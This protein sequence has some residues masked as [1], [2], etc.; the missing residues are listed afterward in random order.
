[1]PTRK[2]RGDNGDGSLLEF[3]KQTHNYM[4][5]IPASRM[6]PP[7]LDSRST[8]VDE[9]AAINRTQRQWIER[10]GRLN[11]PTVGAQ[12]ATVTQHGDVS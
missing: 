4:Q 10:S 12:V 5:I 8:P 11:R 6:P 2:H 7:P 9:T 3:M 1:M